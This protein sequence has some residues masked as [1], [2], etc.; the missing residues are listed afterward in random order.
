MGI[1]NHYQRGIYHNTDRYGDT[2]QAHDV[3]VDS[4]ERHDEKSNQNS[5]WNSD[6]CN[7]RATSVQKKDDDNKRDD[8]QLFEDLHRQCAYRLTDQLGSVIFF[9]Y[10]DT[11]RE[12]RAE[13]F[14]AYLHV[15]DHLLCVLS[16]TH[17][18]D[19]THDF[20]F[21]VFVGDTSAYFRTDNHDRH[22]SDGDGIAPRGFQGNVSYILQAAQVAL[23]AD[24]KLALGNLEE[25]ASHILI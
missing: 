13:F 5:Y 23:S 2:A 19:S 12:P 24:N 17:D 1:L 3:R 10:L 14:D 8:Q 20:S 25:S 16:I 11:R 22:I 9:D 6:D 18:D 7:N 4:Q 15:F 21:A